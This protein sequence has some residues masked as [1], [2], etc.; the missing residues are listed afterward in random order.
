MAFRLADVVPWGRTFA[1]YRAMFRLTDDDLGKALLG[2]GDGPAAFNAEATRLGCR[3]L[4]TDPIYRFSAAQLR[5]RIEQTAQTISQQL[6]E[7]AH[8]FVWDRFEGPQALI[9]A[10]MAAMREFLR[11]Y[12]RGLQE[13]RYVD[14]ALPDLPF[15][16]KRFDLA[17]CSHFL[18]LYSEQC[19][20]AFHLDSISEL[21]RV[22]REI[23]IFPLLELGSVRS[24]HVDAVLSH[25]RD[26]GCF[27]ESLRVDYEFQKGGNE[28][29]R[30]IPHDA[31]GE[32]R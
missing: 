29:L 3:V 25:L 13:G 12:P 10:R 15:E 32:R 18:F 28:M 8:E 14:A 1:E 31:A 20:F 30:V 4:S 26:R 21:C 17:L 2:C 5:S 11:D 27:A 16:G 23:R 19:D 22:A 7:N 24:R 9:D 6:I